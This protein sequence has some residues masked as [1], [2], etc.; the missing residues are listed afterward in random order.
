[1]STDGALKDIPSEL[2][3][4]LQEQ[5][6]AAY[7]YITYTGKFHLLLSYKGKDNRKHLLTRAKVIELTERGQL[8]AQIELRLNLA[9]EGEECAKETFLVNHSGDLLLVRVIK[10]EEGET[11]EPEIIQD[12]EK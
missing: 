8:T 3:Q 4:V 10:F 6:T 7:S 9:S 11:A 12:A 1:M 5:C 2:E